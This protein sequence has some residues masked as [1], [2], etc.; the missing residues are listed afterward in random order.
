MKPQEQFR[1]MIQFFSSHGVTQMN[2]AALERKE[3]GKSVMRNHILERTSD[4]MMEALSWA[5]HANANNHDIYIRPARYVSGKSASWPMVFLDDVPPYAADAIAEKYST[6]V[7][8]TSPGLCHVWLA[9]QIALT[10][11]Q[12]KAVQAFLVAKLL[13]VSS[14]LADMRS[15]SGE[16]FG[17]APGFKNWKR[18]GLWSNLRGITSGPALDPTGHLQNMEQPTPSVSIAT[19]PSNFVFSPRAPR[20][21]VLNHASGDSESEK[22]YAWALGRLRWA[23]SAGKEPNDQEGHIVSQIAARALDR[24][25]R[26]TMAKAIEYATRTYRA[27]L[28][29]L[30]LE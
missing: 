30:C 1:R 12:R 15:T 24:G 23:L 20:V 2:L 16:H 8:E 21:A 28:R 3:N 19:G 5:R 18:H 26:P 29:T 14:G 25:K 7:I 13:S 22:D 11:Q 6:C 17:R 27:A 10:E 4:Q 9:V